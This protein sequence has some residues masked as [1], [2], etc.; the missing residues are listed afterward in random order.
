MPQHVSY[1]HIYSFCPTDVG[2]L[3]LQHKGM[4][5]FIS[6]KYALVLLLL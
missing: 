3:L 4:N 2:L 5:H 1:F 6:V